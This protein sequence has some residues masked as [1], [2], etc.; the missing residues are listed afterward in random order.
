MKCLDSECDG[1]MYH[2]LK[3]M[4]CDKCGRYIKKS[5]L[6]WYAFTNDKNVLNEYLYN[7][8]PMH[9]RDTYYF[10][11]Q[12][13]GETHKM[14]SVDVF[15]DQPTEEYLLWIEDRLRKALNTSRT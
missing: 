2:A 4:K 12:Y 11:R 6:V 14:W 8:K 13:E 10:R 9:D 5:E 15:S 1:Q 3:H 7:R